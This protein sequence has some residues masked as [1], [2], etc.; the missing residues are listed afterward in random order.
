MI[1]QVHRKFIYLTLKLC[2]SAVGEMKRG[3][4]MIHIFIEKMKN[5][6]VPEGTTVNPLIQIDT[7]G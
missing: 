6:N 5:L 4:Y 2:S 3:D 7:L 1:R